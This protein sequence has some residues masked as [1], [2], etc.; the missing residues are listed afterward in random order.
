VQPTPDLGER[1]VVAGARRAQHLVEGTSSGPLCHS[2]VII[3]GASSLVTPGVRSTRR[4]DLEPRR[5]E[6]AATA[7][8]Y[9][10]DWATCHR[11]ATRGHAA[12]VPGGQMARWPVVCAT[13]RP[14]NKDDVGGLT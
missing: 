2:T 6:L 7:D 4:F 5:N 12:P 8:L 11:P 3:A 10:D 14:T 1:L 13:R 9:N